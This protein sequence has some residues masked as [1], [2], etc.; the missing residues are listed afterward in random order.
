LPF[1][2]SMCLLHLVCLIL[3]CSRF[4]HRGGHR[5]GAL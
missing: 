2:V 1:L 3:L 4:Q 5:V